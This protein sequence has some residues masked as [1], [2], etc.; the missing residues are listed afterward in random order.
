M[1]RGSVAFLMSVTGMFFAAWLGDVGQ[2]NDE[3]WLEIV[4]AVIAVLCVALFLAST[5][6]LS[7]GVY[8]LLMSRRGPR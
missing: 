8:R 1:R 2:R 4:G 5:F 7:K 6:W 3:Y